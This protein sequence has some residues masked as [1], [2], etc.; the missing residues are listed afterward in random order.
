MTHPDEQAC[1]KAKNLKV[2]ISDVSVDSHGW[3]AILKSP[4]A[5]KEQE[6]AQGCTTM[7]ILEK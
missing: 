4:K 5:E 2:Q 7:S 3:P 1:K 6:E